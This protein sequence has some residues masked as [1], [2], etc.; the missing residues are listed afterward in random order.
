MFLS[1]YANK[2]APNCKKITKNNRVSLN[3][4][5]TELPVGSVVSPMTITAEYITQ[6]VRS[7]SN[8]M[9]DS[10]CSEIEAV[11]QL[12]DNQVEALEFTIK[13]DS[14]I[15]NRPL[16]ELNLKKGLL[17]CCIVRDGQVITPGGRDVMRKGDTVIVVTTI[18]KM[19]DILNILEK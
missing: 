13:E 8:S 12:V 7:M 9:S 6:Y 10:Y 19:D 17:I 2:I 11:Y 16:Q 3:D 14:K 5:A 18:K 15:T 4:L 1:L